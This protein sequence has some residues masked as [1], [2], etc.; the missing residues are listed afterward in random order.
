MFQTK[1]NRVLGPLGCPLGSS[2]GKVTKRLLV[3][4]VG[5]K[6][7]TMFNVKVCLF[8]FYATTRTHRQN[9]EY[10]SDRYSK[11]DGQVRT[12]IFK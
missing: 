11:G 1:N 4:G 9:R 6:R 3:N 2:I 12:L 7:K 10:L 5:T 8:I